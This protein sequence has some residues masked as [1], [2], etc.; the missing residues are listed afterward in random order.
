MLRSFFVVIIMLCAMSSAQAATE[1][2]VE[3]NGHF[4]RDELDIRAGDS[5]I[6]ING[7]EVTHDVLV[8]DENDRVSDKGLQKPGQE[9]TYYFSEPGTYKVHCAIHPHVKMTVTVH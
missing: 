4:N 6:F 8:I 7:D 3:S 1:K 5:V 2:V 9:V